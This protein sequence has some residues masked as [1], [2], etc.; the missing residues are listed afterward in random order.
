[1]KD[2]SPLAITEPV[3]GYP[4]NVVVITRA[5]G[6]I[7]RVAE[8]DVPL[9]ID[10]DTFSVVPGFQVSAIKHTNNGE[11]PS[12]EFVAVHGSG[13]TFDTLDLDVGRFD[14]AKVEVYKVDRLNLS[15]KGL[16]FTGSISTIQY[17]PIERGVR[18]S[19]KGPASS[20]RIVMTRKRSPMCQTDL[21]NPFLC[22]LNKDDYDVATTVATIEGAF[23]FTVTGALAQA[24]GYFNQG[25]VLTANGDSFEVGAWDQST[26]KITAYLPCSRLLEVGLGLT[27]YPGCD[28]TLTGTRGCAS[29]GNQLN[30]Q[31]EPHF[32]GTAAAAQQV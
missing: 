3:V 12:C 20:S 10:G 13:A 25:L 21:F 28:K 2:L 11:V 8:S 29:F 19:V 22:R 14:G 16:L 23:V 15:R 9:P 24:S 31:G 32:M 26:Q 1:M 5:D 4:A 27:L 7:I 30:F 6:T 18:F 17:S